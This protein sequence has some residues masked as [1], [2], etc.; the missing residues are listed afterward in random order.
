MFD[1]LKPNA[2][3]TWDAELSEDHCIGNDRSYCITHSQV[4][5]FVI[6]NEF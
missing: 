6:F 3:S 1:R 5:V 4:F 2:G